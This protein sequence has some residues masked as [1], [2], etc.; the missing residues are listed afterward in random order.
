MKFSNVLHFFSLSAIELTN[1]N[2]SNF[3]SLMKTKKLLEP[4]ERFE[5]TTFIL[6]DYCF[7][8]E[9]MRHLC[10]RAIIV[11]DILTLIDSDLN[12]AKARA[13]NLIC[14][15][16]V[17]PRPLAPR[18]ALVLF[19]SVFEGVRKTTSLLQVST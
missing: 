18:S 3:N 12:C 17:V 7:G 15:K 1:N 8:P 16:L 19:L 9:L 13:R 4:H 2:F 14:C 10:N 5:L 11:K 6:R